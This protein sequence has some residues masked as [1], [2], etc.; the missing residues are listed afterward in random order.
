MQQLTSV[1]VLFKYQS[2]R[3]VALGR[4]ILVVLFLLAIWFA[5]SEPGTGAFETYALLVLYALLAVAVAAVTW[6]NWWLD[7]WLALP[8]HG[9]DMAVFTAIVFSQNGTTSPFFLFFV[10]PLLSAAIR[11]TWRETA[12]TASALVVLYLV[13]G[14]LLAGTGG[15]ELDRFVLRAGNLVILSLL[16][17]WFG[18]HQRFTRLFSGL[19]IS[20]PRSASARIR[21]RGRSGLRCRLRRL[22][23]GR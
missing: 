1:Q 23:V 7:A 10:L 4:L 6:R 12:L 8:A 14:L 9:V 21:S 20:K 3:V 16:L 2:G 11:W 19:R 13:A 15:F 18:I 22:E 5:R 17:I